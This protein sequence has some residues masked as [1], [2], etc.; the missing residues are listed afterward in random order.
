MGVTNSGSRVHKH[1]VTD[2]ETLSPTQRLDALLNVG[3]SVDSL[4]LSCIVKQ[5]DVINPET[6]A[7]TGQ[8]NAK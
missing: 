8:G 5:M 6:S 2:P 3:K 4:N 1:Q 7:L